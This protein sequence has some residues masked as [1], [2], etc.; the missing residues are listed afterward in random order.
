MTGEITHLSYMAQVFGG[1]KA[2]GSFELSAWILT[3]IGKVEQ[4]IGD[5]KIN[6]W[7]CEF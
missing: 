1:G 2:E 3:G 7:T 5:G 6:P 4:V